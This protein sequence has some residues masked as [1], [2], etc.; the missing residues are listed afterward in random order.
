MN[1]PTKVQAV[2]HKNAVSQRF[3]NLSLLR[4]AAKIQ[5]CFGGILKLPCPLLLPE[6]PERKCRNFL[7]AEVKRL[8]II[9]L[10]GSKDLSRCKVAGERPPT[11]FYR[12]CMGTGPTSMTSGFPAKSIPR[13]GFFA[14]VPKEGRSWRK[15]RPDCPDRGSKSA[16]GRR[17]DP[18]PPA[19]RCRA[20]S[21]GEALDSYSADRRRKSC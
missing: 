16:R 4:A 15:A 5:P 13:K 18:L 19:A 6:N 10:Y 17:T 3:V 14:A 11:L 7:S 20:E 21:S 8:R 12:L 2:R 1:Y 9:R